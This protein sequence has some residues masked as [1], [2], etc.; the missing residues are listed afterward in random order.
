MRDRLIDLK[1]CL[2]EIGGLQV[3]TPEDRIGMQKKIYLLQETGRVN[4]G[5][6]FK[7]FIKGPYSSGLTEDMSDLWLREEWVIEDAAKCELKDEVLE[8]I[9]YI[10]PLLEIENLDE[11]L[12]KH[13]WS[14]L[15]ASIHFLKN[16]V[17][18][19]DEEELKE[20]IREQFPQYTNKQVCLA[21][22]ML[23]KWGLFSDGAISSQEGGVG[24]EEKT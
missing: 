19:S 13:E 23:E 20:T 8:K 12:K 9:N 5:Y 1:L 11:Q 17:C 16:K 14:V 7:W 24:N 22:E 4:L 10:K 2:D 18:K 3:S 21:K 6:G 15:L